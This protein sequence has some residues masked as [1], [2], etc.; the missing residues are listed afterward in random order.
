MK[1]PKP[2]TYIAILL[3]LLS[4]ILFGLMFVVPFL[5]VSLVQKGIVVSAL[6]IGMEITWW[7]GVALVGRQLLT[8]YITY[9]NPRTWFSRKNRERQDRENGM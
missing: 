9:L 5:P 3:I 4:G 6:A 2:D 7:V 8:R 1:N